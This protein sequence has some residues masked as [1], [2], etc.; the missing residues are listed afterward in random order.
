MLTLPVLCCAVLCCAVLCCAVIQYTTHGSNVQPGVK[1]GTRSQTV[2]AVWRDGRVEQRERYVEKVRKVPGVL[3]PWCD[4]DRWL[5]QWC[6]RDF[7]AC[8]HQAIQHW[9][10][11]AVFQALEGLLWQGVACRTLLNAFFRQYP[12]GVPCMHCT[13][14]TLSPQDWQRS[15]TKLHVQL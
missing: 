9:S 1:Y 4:G 13:G 7:A 6:S 12:V 11:S 10:T 8:V 14:H 2:I 15:C 3:N 5:G